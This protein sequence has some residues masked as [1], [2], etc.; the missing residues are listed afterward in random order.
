MTGHARKLRGNDPLTAVRPAGGGRGSR[1]S[2][3]VPPILRDRLARWFMD[4]CNP[5]CAQGGH[6]V[7]ARVF[8]Y[9]VMHHRGPGWNY[10]QVKV[11]YRGGVWNAYINGRGWWIW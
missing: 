7:N 6:W 4:T 11:T 1:L 8:F 5:S 2:A 10:S 9:N 3:P